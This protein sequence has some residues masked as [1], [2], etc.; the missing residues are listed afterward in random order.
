M[1]F[2]EQMRFYCGQQHVHSRQLIVFQLLVMVGL[3][4]WVPL[5]VAATDLLK[6]QVT[7]FFVSGDGY[8]VT[9]NHVAVGCRTPAVLTP[10]G[11]MA[12]DLVAQSNDLD[13][14]V[15][16]TRR[17]PDA[18]GRFSV[19]PSQ[20]F[21][22]ALSVTRFLHKGGLGSGSTISGR[23]LGRTSAQ[24]GRFAMRTKD[25]IAGGNSGSPV[26]DY[27]GG[28][29][30]MMVA[31]ARKDPRVGIAVD[32]FAITE[33]LSQSGINVETVAGG[34]YNP[35]AGGATATRRYTFPL[36]CLPRE[37]NTVSGQE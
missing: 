19:D 28:I 6:N 17:K 31:R 25:T 7:G 15:I 23:F 18:Y 30:G 10:F 14:A 3:S 11:F 13:V 9:A 27:R 1:Q 4:L 36:V 24:G 26:F 5:A 37:K 32:V 16:K 21:R 2:I 33:F 35:L 12:G 29:V 34:E 22:R 8:F 20:S